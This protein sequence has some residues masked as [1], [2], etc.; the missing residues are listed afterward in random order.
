MDTIGTNRADR[1]EAARRERVMGDIPTIRCT[2]CNREGTAKADIGIRGHKMPDGWEQRE[3]I[4]PIAGT[5]L[6]RKWEATLCPDC[7][8]KEPRHDH[9]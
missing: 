9:E 1:P 6:V 2:N 7:A 5:E 3:I 8:K 4:D